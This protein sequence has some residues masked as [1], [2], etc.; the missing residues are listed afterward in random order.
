MQEAGYDFVQNVIE[1][2]ESFDSN[3]PTHQVAE[4]LAIKKS[5]VHTLEKNQLLVTADS[6]VVI[7]EQILG[8]PADRDQAIEFL[9]L[10]SGNT[11]L[12]HTGV[13]LRSA[14]SQQSFTSTSEVRM[15]ALSGDEIIHYVDNYSPY[16]RA[17]SYGI[18][19][20]LGHNCIDRIKGSYTNIMGLPTARLY[21][22]L[23][24]FLGK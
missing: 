16:D 22:E 15:E 24:K 5:S 8:K 7:D 2:D 11:H 1:V 18:Q 10:L 6:I 4:Y 17:G 23:R 3:M 12:V 19:D 9:Q 13:C 14:S 21:R 20:W